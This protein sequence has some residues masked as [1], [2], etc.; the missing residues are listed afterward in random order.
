MQ[1]NSYSEFI[2]FKKLALRSISDKDTV[3]L[4]EACSDNRIPDRLF[5]RLDDSASSLI[6]EVKLNSKKKKFYKD[7]L[8]KEL[9]YDN[10]P[11]LSSLLTHL[12]LGVVGRKRIRDAVDIKPFTMLKEDIVLMIDEILREGTS[13]N[14]LYNLLIT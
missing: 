4:L 9:S 1:F 7:L 13:R 14:K 5:L 8:N 10:L 3:Y 11:Q 12:L 2:Y 6:K